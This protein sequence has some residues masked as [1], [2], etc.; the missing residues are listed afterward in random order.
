MLK[1]SQAQAKLKLKLV[2]QFSMSPIAQSLITIAARWVLPGTV[3]IT[4]ATQPAQTA[5]NIGFRSCDACSETPYILVC[6]I[7]SLDIGA[8]DKVDG[9]R[10]CREVERW[11]CR[12]SSE[13]P[14]KVSTRLVML[15]RPHRKEDPMV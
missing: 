14:L 11:L 4:V 5:S 7:E 6:R 12:G 15:K 9:P 3:I 10:D 13:N 8:W 2:R 1:P